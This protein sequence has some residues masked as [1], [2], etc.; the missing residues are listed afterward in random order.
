ME[1]NFENLDPQ[2]NET[3]ETV[4]S[5]VVATKK[6]APLWKRVL[7]IGG[8]SLGV[9]I[10]AGISIPYIFK[11]KIVEKVKKEIN[12]NVN[13]KIEFSDVSLSL[14]RHFP[15]FSV[16]LE[17]LKVSGIG[18]FAGTDL[19]KTDGLDLNLDFWSVVGGGNP[20]KLNS[21]HLEKP[22]LHVIAL[23]DGSANYQITKP[24]DPNAPVSAF[25]L[26]LSGYS[27]H[28]GH[29]IYDDKGMDFLL[30]LDQMQHEGSGEMTADVYD[31]VTRTQAAK[32]TVRYGNLY[33]LSNAKTDLDAILNINL[34]DMKFSFKNNKL[35]V[36]EMQV[37][38]DGFMQ[39]PPNGDIV[40]DLKFDAPLNDFKNLLSIVPGA[41]TS[42]YSDV[43]ANGKFSF[44]AAVKGIYNGL[45]AK[46]PS[47]LFNL[48]LAGAAV[49]YPKLPLGVSDITA[50]INLNSSSSN[51]DEMKLDIPAF[52]LKV[53]SNPL[54]GFFSLRTPLSDPDVDTK[55]NGVLN[56]AELSQALPLESIQ[57]L[58]GLITANLAVKAK[59]SAVDKKAYDQVNMNGGLQIQNMTMQPKGKP[60]VNIQNM[61]MNFTPNN[62]NVGNFQ[63][64][65]GKSDVTASGTIDNILAYF[66]PDR[67]LTG[68]VTMSA[69]LIDA[70]EW[71][72]PEKKAANT[73]GG[74]KPLTNAS[75]TAVAAAK[76]FDRFNFTVNAK[77]NQI[78]Y[79][80][81]N[82][83][84]I[85]A[86]GNFTPNKFTISNF[87]TN[88]GNSDIGGN[89]ILTGVFD[90]LFD[91]RILG[92]NLNVTSTFFDL[93]QF[94]TAAPPPNTGGGASAPAVATEPFQIPKNVDVTL[95]GK[96]GR[97]LYT[98]MDMRNVTG[99]IVVANEEARIDNATANA[100]DGTINIKGGYNAKDIN[101]PQ[102]NLSF[103][104]KNV[105]FQQTFK[106]FNSFQKI[107]PVGE[108]IKGKFNTTMSFSG[109]MGKDLSPNL[110]TLNAAGIFQTLQGALAGFKPL[111]GLA[112]RLN[113]PELKSGLDLRDTKNFFEV[114]DGHFQVQEFD[115]KVKD[116]LL[117]ISGS[118]SFTNEMNYLV[119]ARLP[120][121]YLQ[122]NAA[123]AAVG[124]AFDG[125][126]KEASKYGVNIN[127]S[128]FLNVQFNITGGMNAPKISMKIL[129][130]E[131][132]TIQETGKDVVNAAIQKAEDSIR[133][134][135]NQELDKMKDRAKTEADRATD[136]LARL[137]QREADKLKDKAVEEAKKRAGEKL[138]EETKKRVE[139]AIDK[140]GGSD[141]IKEQ[142]DKL[143]G[144]LDKFDPFKKKEEKPKE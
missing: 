126:L 27:I 73:G 17:N 56:L 47:I 128:E 111:E 24:A 113:M 64:K 124:S 132:K 63:A 2:P 60:V 16:R 79:G 123:G 131:G 39:M 54:E 133:T 97:V 116:V 42:Q 135:A 6:R 59:M 139:G 106:T 137:A 14:F 136:S 57:N 13:A 1:N 127:N 40:M 129:G 101:K 31:L 3:P 21:L 18:V 80:N 117:K 71:L 7:K 114:K 84:N 33:S 45:Q 25:K 35:I 110:N 85:A 49:Q 96:M 92:G 4:I 58:N 81:H 9:L 122:Q 50:K 61:T 130:G 44:N 89:G 32:S 11:D 95:N 69:N 74:T 5:N 115:K 68:N 65:L 91:N 66:K 62:V 120:R 119:K 90:W 140:V 28:D 30:D 83:S 72:E 141:K 55:V 100:F 108:Y 93:N 20:Y 112:E 94:M 34:K 70:N 75:P 46:M 10:A 99:R 134:R 38:A 8:I 87:K 23:P 48:D 26:N 41:Y 107:A 52:K 104:F 143:K 77:A 51:F 105:D 19:L 109:E 12:K 15:K 53:G 37:H 138:G 121:K 88:I 76:P 142:T 98:N 22:T 102:Y 67:T 36:N 103:D 144:K 86:T 82:I 29:V 125:L 118:H 78:L 43:K